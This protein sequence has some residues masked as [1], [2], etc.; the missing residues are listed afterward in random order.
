M[1]KKLYFTAPGK[2]EIRREQMP[3]LK[4]NECLIRNIAT[5]ISPGTELALFTGTHVGFKDP[6]I[7]WAKYP[8]LP[9]YAS[10]GEV[11]E[12]KGCLE[13]KPGDKVM[14][15]GPHSSHGVLNEKQDTWAA[16]DRGIEESALFGRFAQISATVPY[17][18]RRTERGGNI[19]VF[20]AGLIG[21]F[22]AQL[23]QLDPERQVIIADISSNRLSLASE[24]GLKYQVNSADENPASC[25]NQETNGAGVDIVVEATGVPELVET[26]L[27]L[28]NP[29]GTVYLLGSPRGEV[30]INAYKMIHRKGTSLVGAHESVIG[31]LVSEGPDHPIRTLLKEMIAHIRLGRIK[32][33]GMIT[34]RIVPE[35]AEEYYN[36][37]IQDPDN[38]LG[39]LIEWSRK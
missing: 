24:C 6:D 19:F 10:I 27:E 32:T 33:E 16:I 8:L 22:C 26:S 36:N 5:L 37:L 7:H 11:T 31:N 29:G 14:Y 23:F 25:I 20:G 15:Y 4:T 38:Y 17:L 30:S 2:V 9:G 1:R 34:H 3:E 21:N 12:I 39:V 13:L 35:Q 18:A 28:V